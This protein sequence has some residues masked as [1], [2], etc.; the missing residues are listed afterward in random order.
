MK[1]LKIR[2]FHLGSGAAVFLGYEP[3]TPGQGFNFLLGPKAFT[4]GP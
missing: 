3:M 2:L 1:E 4:W